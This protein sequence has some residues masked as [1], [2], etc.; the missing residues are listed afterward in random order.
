MDFRP[1]NI[2]KGTDGNGN[3]IRVE[4]WDNDTLAN[5]EIFDGMGNIMFFLLLV[6]LAGPIAA[7]AAILTFNGKTNYF[8]IGGLIGA[9]FTLCDFWFNGFTTLILA[10]LI[11]D[12]EKIV[13]WISILN[14]WSLIPNLLLLLFS[15]QI[16]SMLM[17]SV[18]T[19][20]NRQKIF[21]FF[22][23]FCFLI[24][25]FIL[26]TKLNDNSGWYTKVVERMN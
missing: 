7:I 9:I 11:T 2:F 3:P 12:S 10:W 5:A 22:F 26:M 18:K 24:T 17:N 8:T 21:F 25:F 6:P 23:V 14:A 16:H 13:N 19:E 1:K 15:N 20:E 4:Q